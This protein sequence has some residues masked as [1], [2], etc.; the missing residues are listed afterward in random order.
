MNVNISWVYFDKTVIFTK[1]LLYVKTFRIEIL[2]I[3]MINMKE[4][5]K[6]F[7]QR[8][9]D[10]M[11]GKNVCRSLIIKVTA[12]SPHKMNIGW[13]SNLWYQSMSR[14]VWILSECNTPE[15]KINTPACNQYRYYHLIIVQQIF[16]F[17]KA[18]TVWKL[19][20]YPLWRIIPKCVHWSLLKRCQS[21]NSPKKS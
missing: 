15:N 8:I 1:K 21:L 16:I 19:S 11:T 9:V 6:I 18:F 20:T 7:R 17:T 5:C 13:Q 4:D 12:S 2:M 3:L 14:N 10:T